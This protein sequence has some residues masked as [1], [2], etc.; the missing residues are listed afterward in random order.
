MPSSASGAAGDESMATASGVQGGQGGYRDRDPPPFF[1]GSEPEGFRQYLRDLSLWEWESEIPK[2]K[3]AVKVLRQ[4]GGTAKSAANEVPLDKIRSAEG[5]K[6]ILS[7]LKEH[8]QPHLESA[9]PRAFEK[10]VYGES[11]K[12]KESMQGF[13]IRMDQAFQELSEE[14]VTLPDVVKGYIIYRQANLT[15]TQEDQ[16]TTWTSGHY[17]REEIVKALRKL[18]KVSREKG[19]KHYVMEETYGDHEERGSSLEEH[20]TDFEIENFVYLEEGDL[21]NI[22]E[23]KDLVEAL[24]TYQQV[25]KAIRDQ[26]TSRGW[27]NYKGGGKGYG[28]GSYGKGGNNFRMPGK[29]G[30][31]VHVE[32]L[33]LRTKC[34]RCGM[35]GHWARECTNAPDDYS[36]SRAAGSVSTAKSSGTTMSGKSGFVQIDTVREDVDLDNKTFYQITLGSFLKKKENPPMFCGISTEASQGVVD[37]AAQSGLIGVHALSQF[38]EELRRCGL[39]YKMTDRK[40]QARGVGGEATVKGVVELPI[41]IAGVNGILEAT[42]VTEDVPLLLPVKLLRE[43]QAVINLGTG[44]L[45]LGQYQKATY[46]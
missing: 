7:K 12:N 2:E 10:A 22:F 24:A 1:D 29:G 45:E 35:I 27:S 5:V 17:G 33:K 18:E 13:V 16:V 36:R 40:G 39:K 26:K 44:K 32:S 8:F 46:I 21:N 19:G 41:G 28:S 6:A 34:A 20:E 31:R 9:M 11:R 38:S 3:H 37:T 30:S 42:V 14:Q 15:Q 23:E 43:L 4:L 25:R